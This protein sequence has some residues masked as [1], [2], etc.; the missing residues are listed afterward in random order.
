MIQ[1]GVLLWQVMWF[2]LLTLMMMMMQKCNAIFT[3][4]GPFSE[5][6]VTT[7]F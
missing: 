5:I 1:P 7:I 4:E 2:T 6:A 3:G